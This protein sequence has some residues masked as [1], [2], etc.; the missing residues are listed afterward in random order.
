MFV[1]YELVQ[2]SEIEYVLAI[3][4]CLSCGSQV[5]YK[6]CAVLLWWYRVY[7]LFLY[8]FLPGASERL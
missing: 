5:A 1:L 8:Q 4:P 7:C 2:S 3:A 6:P